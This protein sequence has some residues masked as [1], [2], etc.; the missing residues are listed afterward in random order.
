MAKKPTK[1]KKSEVI[2]RLVRAVEALKKSR[3]KEMTAG[4]FFQILIDSGIK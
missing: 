2:Y 4:Q 1:I 3:A